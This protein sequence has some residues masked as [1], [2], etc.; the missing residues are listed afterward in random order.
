MDA[1]DPFSFVLLE[2]DYARLAAGMREEGVPVEFARAILTGFWT[3]GLDR[4]PVKA[5]L[6]G[7]F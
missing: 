3:T 5:R 2:Y 4:P 7:R 1:G 6:R